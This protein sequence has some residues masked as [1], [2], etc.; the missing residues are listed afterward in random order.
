M[1]HIQVLC[2]GCCSF[3]QKLYQDK[4]GEGM[5]ELLKDS[6]AIDGST[7]N[8]TKVYYHNSHYTTCPGSS[9]LYL[10][11]LVEHTEYYVH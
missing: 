8:Q 10:I 6:G 11:H 3:L 9:V 1:L 2:N 5:V 4:L 7:L